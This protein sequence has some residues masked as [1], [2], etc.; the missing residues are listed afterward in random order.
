MGLELKCERKVKND[1]TPRDFGKMKLAF[2]QTGM[3]GRVDWKGKLGAS[4]GCVKFAITTKYLS[5]DLVSR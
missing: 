4:F 1:L 3:R 5:G 2:A